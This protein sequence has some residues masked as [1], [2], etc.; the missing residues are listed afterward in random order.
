[1]TPSVLRIYIYVHVPRFGNITA[2][3]ETDFG[4]FGLP[5]ELEAPA[6]R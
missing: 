5:L 3:V 1:M 2:Y 6:N 4:K